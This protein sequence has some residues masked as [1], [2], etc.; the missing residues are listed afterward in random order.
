MSSTCRRLL[1]SV[2]PTYFF[3]RQHVKMVKA[4]PTSLS[5]IQKMINFYL[6]FVDWS[7]GL[8]RMWLI[9]WHLLDYFMV[10]QWWQC[11]ISRFWWFNISLLLNARNPINRTCRNDEM[12]KWTTPRGTIVFMCEPQSEFSIPIC[13]SDWPIHYHLYRYQAFLSILPSNHQIL[14]KNSFSQV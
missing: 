6:I 1:P 7:F 9:V 4:S 13:H 14:A 5:Q 8:I 10:I 3:S 12:T 11:Q 2:I